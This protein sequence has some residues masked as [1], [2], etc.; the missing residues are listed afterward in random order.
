VSV[1]TGARQPGGFLSE[2]GE[3]GALMRAHDWTRSPLGPPDGWPAS[4]RTAVSICLSSRFPIV[5]WW[6][7][8]LVMLYND[9]YRPLL[10]DKHPRALGQ[11]ADAAFPELWGVIG[12]MLRGVVERGEATWSDDQL[13]PLERSG[14]LEEAYFTFSY[15][16]VRDEAGH[17]LGVFTAVTETTGRV[18]MERRLRTLTALASRTAAARTVAEVCERAIEALALNPA[19]LPFAE[20]HVRSGD[21]L[22]LAAA[23]GVAGAAPDPLRLAA[24]ADGGA[25][26]VLDGVA[27]ALPLPRPG[28]RARGVLVAG[29]APRRALDHDYRE[30]FRAV[31]G[32]LSTAIATAQGF[33]D[34]LHRAAALAELDLAKTEFFS[35]VSHEFRTPLTLLIGPLADAV[36]DT[37]TPLSE[38]QL[39]RIE[40]AQRG[41]TRLL[42]LVNTLLDFS[43]LQAGRVEPSSQP[44]DLGARVRA[45]A[46]GFRSLVES[47][48][49]ALSVSVPET[50]VIVVADPEMVER[51]LLNLLSNAFKFTLQGEI[52]LT[53]EIRGE[54][55][56]LVVA[57]TGTGISVDEQPRVFERFHR[58]RG[59][60]AR[61]YEGSGIGLALVRELVELQE[62]SITVASAPGVGTAFTVELPLAAPD[63]EPLV[64]VAESDEAAGVLV[65]AARW[66][67]PAAPAVAGAV[68]SRVLV[69][70]DNADMRDYLAG[71]LGAHCAV[72]T[73]ADGV[74]ALGLLGTG[75]FDLVVTDAMMP[76]LDGLGLLRA[77]RAD[78]ATRRLPVI[79]LSARAGE[80]ATIEGLDAGAD[81]YLVKPFSANELVARV[82]ASLELARLRD[83]IAAAEH[84]RAQQAERLAETLQRSLLPER[85][86]ELPELELAGR[87]VPAGHE[88]K[89]G[90]DWYDAVPLADGRVVLAIGDVA[91]HGIRAATIMGEASH[92]LRAYA[93]EGHEPAELMQ[94]LDALV[95]AGGLDMITCV[96]AILTPATG[97]LRWVSAGHPPALVLASGGGVHTLEGPIACP[98]GVLPE[99]RH[100]EGATV[101]ADGEALVFYTDGLV[102]R[103]GESIDAGIGR[104]AASLVPGVD[105]EALCDRALAALLGDDEPADDVAMLIARRVRLTAPTATLVQPAT[106]DR[107][108]DIR[109]WVEAWLR[110]NE[111]SGERAADLVLAVHE[112]SM[113]AIEHAYGP[114]GGTVEIRVRR[115]DLVAEIEV[116]DSGTWRAERRDRD[117]GR[118]E[119]LMRALVDEF[120]VEHVDGG[121]RVR[122]RT[123]FAR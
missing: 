115:T 27:V 26:N 113:N 76:R 116:R 85:L 98:L 119:P 111:L 19:D 49:L 58:V 9:P 72:G 5:L 63:A 117:R 77:L 31:A 48:G 37:T 7:P 56:V 82:R 61:S 114:A 47:S 1:T 4:L 6:G 100:R 68:G 62:G 101:L 29:I 36:S 34:G 35:N 92:A 39:E 23:T 109:R 40:T 123:D 110:G 43:R 14:Y 57:D 67:A 121:S 75:E 12:P 94:R 93:R 60:A 103:R 102:E 45:T 118:G 87:Y 8:E 13:L 3:M 89:V 51:V 69:V 106:P 15:S 28:D 112:A 64:A 44:L 53:L 80:E 17:T 22:R 91:G 83:E 10:A 105:A 54:H 50:P 81:D 74:E 73:A 88:L 46:G 96:C 30:F 32:L 90:G 20:I 66:G 25:E 97:E 108:R 2:G 71:L 42:R 18:L 41:A 120:A 59:A 33:E 70:D 16:P 104:L 11:A 79:L 38:R 65:E 122:L 95:Q 21:A 52:R 86:P 107:L 99:T 84:E 24:V 55:A 78:P